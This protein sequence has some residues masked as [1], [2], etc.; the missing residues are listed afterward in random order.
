MPQPAPSNTQFNPAT[1][2]AN[3]AAQQTASLQPMPPRPAATQD[4]PYLPP[5]GDLI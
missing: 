1:T 5:G 2:A 3:L 4:F